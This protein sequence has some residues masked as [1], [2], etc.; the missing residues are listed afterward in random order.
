MRL[1][2]LLTAGSFIMVAITAPVPKGL[3][4]GSEPLDGTWRVVEWHLAGNRTALTDD[5]LWTISGETLTV[6]GTNQGVGAGFVANA[7]RTVWRP[8]GG[9]PNEIDYTIIYDGGTQHSFRP[10]VFELDGDTFKICLSATAN[11]PRPAACKSSEGVLYV[12]KRVTD[13]KKEEKKVK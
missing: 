12:L 1:L 13:V 5:I 2:A 4:K 11:G 10:S 9:A 3:K 8:E 7:T 6:E